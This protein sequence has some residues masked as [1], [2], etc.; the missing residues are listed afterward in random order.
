[1]I[2]QPESGLPGE[3]V[4]FLPLAESVKWMS[5]DRKSEMCW[6]IS[7]FLTLPQEIF[8]NLLPAAYSWGLTFASQ[9]STCPLVALT[10]AFGELEEKMTGFHFY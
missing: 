2:P 5:F 1:M 7:I 8:H 6:I 9:S 10:G 3:W 4:A